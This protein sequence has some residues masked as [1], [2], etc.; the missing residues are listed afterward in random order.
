M[1]TA[2]YTYSFTRPT[3]VLTL[4]NAEE[5]VITGIIVS[6]RIVQA[7]EATFVNVQKEVA[8]KKLARKITCTYVKKIKRA[9][10]VIRKWHTYK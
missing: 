3:L 8:W 9:T 5:S 7:D 6:G 10:S 4:G 1:I 2:K